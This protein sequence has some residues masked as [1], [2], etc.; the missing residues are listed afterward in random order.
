MSIVNNNTGRL[1][2]TAFVAGAVVGG[3]CALLWAPQSGERTRRMIARKAA[4]GRDYVRNT[5]EDL[6]HKADDVADRAK[7]VRRSGE[8]FLRKYA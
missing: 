8:N 6:K 5:T 3:V 2:L 4:D 1:A 7:D